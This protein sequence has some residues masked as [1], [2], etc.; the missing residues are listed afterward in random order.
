M[1]TTD[2]VFCDKLQ[3]SAFAENKLAYANWCEFP[4]GKG[5][6]LIATK[7][8]FANYFD[9]TDK[10]KS[11]IWELVDQ[12]KKIIDAEYKPCAYNI[13]IN[14]GEDAGQTVFHVHVHLI[15]RYKGDMADPRGGVRGVI[16]EK[17]N[18]Q[19]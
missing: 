18:W 11:A 4:V 5:H 19:K 12:A 1:K 3:K 2:C 7:R 15:P 16:P 17:Q 14:C 9:A 10:E 6:A 8:C 13:G